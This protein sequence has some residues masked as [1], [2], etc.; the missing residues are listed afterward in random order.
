MADNIK[1][2][3][4]APTLI[5][6]GVLYSGSVTL[7]G[8]SYVELILSAGG[9]DTVSPSTA[10]LT[11]GQSIWYTIT[12]ENSSSGGQLR[13]TNSVL[14]FYMASNYCTVNYKAYA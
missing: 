10:T 6:S 7:T 11:A 12:S 9:G 13:F 1:R 14:S 2:I 5:K 8:A 3:Q 4:F